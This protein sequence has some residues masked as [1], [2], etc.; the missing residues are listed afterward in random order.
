VG[1]PEDLGPGST[2]EKRQE[3]WQ[4]YA[5][6]TAQILPADQDEGQLARVRALA[7]I[8]RPEA[9]RALAKVAVF[10]SAE[11]TRARAIEALS[12]R[13]EGDYTE[14]LVQGLRYPW[15]QAAR[16]AAIAIVALDR[17]DLLPHL[18]AMADQ[19]DP[20][21]PITEELEG[22][23]VT[24]A[25][26]IVRINHHR[27]C[28]LCHPPAERG[29]TPE[30]TLVAETPV[31]SEPFPDSSRGYGATESNLLVRIDA[32]YLRQ[33]FSVLQPVREHSA[34]PAQQ[35]F[36]FFVRKRVL[37]PAEALDLR[38][39]LAKRE[40]GELSPYQS[41]AAQAIRALKGRNPGAKV[42][43]GGGLAGT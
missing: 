16:N 30:D 32:T 38:A 6:V 31:P 7:A 20:R 29:K 19:P 33:D 17:K 14:V 13:R 36:D 5:A 25:H 15:P 21:S 10:S 8:P 4:T 22:K 12:V 18:A 1:L 42:K 37:T 27:N 11:A 23:K 24:V 3:H 35:R 34:W 41:A 26:E 9:T 28:L 39:R 43:P 40:P 2:E